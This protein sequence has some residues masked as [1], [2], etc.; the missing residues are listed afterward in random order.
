MTVFVV[1]FIGYRY[2]GNG[3]QTFLERMFWVR[4]CWF[5]NGDFEIVDLARA[6]VCSL[7][8][9]IVNPIQD[10]FQNYRS[11]RIHLFD[12]IN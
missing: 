4:P 9:I 1:A 11:S 8:H 6:L 2:S 7:L 3:V 10:S 5:G 12:N